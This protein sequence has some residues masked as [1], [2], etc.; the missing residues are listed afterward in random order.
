MSWSDGATMPD[1]VL[2]RSGP[3][4][5]PHGGPDQLQA[6][7]VLGLSLGQEDLYVR[8]GDGTAGPIAVRGGA[9]GNQAHFPDRVRNAVERQIQWT[10]ASTVTGGVLLLD[11]ALSTF[12]TPPAFL[13][14]LVARAHDRG[15]SVIAISKRSTLNI[16]GLPLAYWLDGVP[17]RACYRALSVPFHQENAG[18]RTD[19]IMGRL[20]A[21]RF[22]PLGQTFRLDLSPA[23]GLSDEEALSRLFSSIRV[24][25]GYPESSS[26][27]TL[28]L[29]SRLRRY[30]S[31]GHNWSSTGYRPPGTG[32]SAGRSAHLVARTKVD[33]D[34]YQKGFFMEI[35]YGNLVWKS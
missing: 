30:S 33:G 34:V 31:S 14:R 16:K 4:R 24:R 28:S 2:Y 29:W 11:G 13:E 23:P 18:R 8:M 12:D 7:H 9:A 22:S 27:R 26:R 17:C 10:A 1:A 25:G 35:L 21:C 32:G 15:N 5:L 20:F 19:R 3:L 6:L